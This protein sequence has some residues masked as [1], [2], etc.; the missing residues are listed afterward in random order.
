MTRKIYFIREKNSNTW[1]SS[2]KHSD[3]ADD[4][5]YAAVFLRKENA[6]KAIKEM[7]RGLNPKYSTFPYWR[8]RETNYRGMDTGREEVPLLV[9]EFE[10]V[11]FE[12]NE[13]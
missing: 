13:V 8:L 3:F 7:T 12:L 1:C 10:A 2:S 9:P 4:F 5:D 11:G 6:D